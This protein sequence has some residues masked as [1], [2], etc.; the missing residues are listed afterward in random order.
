MA[1]LIGTLLKSTWSFYKLFIVQ[2]ISLRCL[3]FLIVNLIV[4]KNILFA[5]FSLLLITNSCIISR[6]NHYR[7]LS[8]NDRAKIKQLKSF[9]GLNKN[10]IYEITAN[11]LVKE[12]ENHPKSLVYI[13]TSGCSGDTV[14]SL[15]EIEEYAKQNDFKLFLILTGYWQLNQTLNQNLESQL[16]SINAK[17]YGN[18]NKSGYTTK[19]RNELGYKNYYAIHKKGGNYMFFEGNVLKEMKYDL[20]N[21]N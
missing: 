21:P 7:Y 4:M 5:L 15:S 1:I 9:D 6:G 20:V 17:E 3:L 13:F 2:Q 8:E 14:N 11:Q 19:F 10:Y 16:F 18:P 12:L